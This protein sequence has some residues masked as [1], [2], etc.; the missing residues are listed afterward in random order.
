MAHPVPTNVF[1]SQAQKQ[2][3]CLHLLG[4]LT[5]LPLSHPFYSC[6]ANFFSKKCWAKW[7]HLLTSTEVTQPIVQCKAWRCYESPSRLSK[8]EQWKF[9]S[10]FRISMAMAVPFQNS[11]R[12]RCTGGMLHIGNGMVFCL[13][14]LPT[15]CTELK[16][17]LPSNNSWMT[18]LFCLWTQFNENYWK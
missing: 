13:L 17:M 9:V 14:S 5:H 1:Y 12:Q 4:A 2:P 8:N 18:E 7:H 10:M 16:W 11:M 3:C 6:T 15:R